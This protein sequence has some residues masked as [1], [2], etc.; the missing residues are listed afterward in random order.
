MIELNEYAPQELKG[1]NLDL[2]HDLAEVVQ[3]LSQVLPPNKI[4]ELFSST[5]Q[6][7]GGRIVFPYSR[8]DS[9]LIVARD[10]I[11]M[12]DHYKGQLTP[13]EIS[14]VFLRGSNQ[15]FEAVTWVEIGFQGLQNLAVSDAS[16]NWTS[17]VGHR[18]TDEERA[19]RIM[20]SGKEMYHDFLSSFAMYRKDNN[21]GGD[22][23]EEF[24]LEHLLEPFLTQKST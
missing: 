10:S 4:W 14:E 1:A 6:E 21:M 9:C 19:E 8:V 5:P 23:F 24:G 2:Q 20:I 15:A 16:R 12:L 17:G 13:E 3:R 22:L 18:V 11:W 7:T